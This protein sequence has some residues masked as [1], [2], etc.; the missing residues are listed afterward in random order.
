MKG[1]KADKLTLPKIAKK[2]KLPIED[3]TSQLRLGIKTE[4]EHTDNKSKAKEIAMDHLAE[5]PKYYTK[6]KKA[7]L[8]EAIGKSLATAALGLSLI[9]NPSASKPKQSI[10][11]KSV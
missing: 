1:G 6:L 11:D 3:L 5:D 7:K 10:S 9:G 4:M 2:H 8:E